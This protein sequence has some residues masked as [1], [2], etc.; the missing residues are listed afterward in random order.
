MKNIPE[1]NH[2]VPNPDAWWCRECKAHTGFDTSY[3][4]TEHGGGKVWKC[5]ACEREMSK[6]GA[7][8]NEAFMFICF[9]CCGLFVI[10]GLLGVFG[11]IGANSR[12]EYWWGVLGLLVFGA[13]W[14]LGGWG[15]AHMRTGWIAWCASQERKTESQLEKEGL[16]HPFQAEFEDSE[17]FYEWAAQF[18][19]SDEECER[20]EEKY[21]QG[22]MPSF[23][24]GG[25]DD[26]SS[27]PAPPS[28]PPTGP[29][30]D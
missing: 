3:E 8:E 19:D 5:K 13:I 24:A 10:L 14:G 16:N 29:P 9:G 2:C 27:D 17:S 18:F 28:L 7:G 30:E 23:L 1:I 4:I 11:V 15:F 22:K 20:F 25:A 12:A 6:P 21:W 26:P